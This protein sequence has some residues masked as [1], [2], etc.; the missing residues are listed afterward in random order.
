MKYDT[1]G[2]LMKISCRWQYDFYWQK[3]QGD[4]N[5][6][7]SVFSLPDKKQKK[8]TLTEKKKKRACKCLSDVCMDI[9]EQIP[10]KKQKKNLIHM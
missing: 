3:I 9:V 2:L 1:S 7:L 10:F 8:N 4:D 6:L 5:I